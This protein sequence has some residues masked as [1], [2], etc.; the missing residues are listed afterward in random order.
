ML[1]FPRVQHNSCDHRGPDGQ[2]RPVRGPVARPNDAPSSET[3]AGR[4]P[5]GGVTHRLLGDP[6]GGGASPVGDPGREPVPVRVLLFLARR[7][8]PQPAMDFSAPRAARRRRLR[9]LCGKRDPRKTGIPLNP[10]ALLFEGKLT[11]KINEN[12]K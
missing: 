12:F 1:C 5:T 9:A 6:D 4:Q 7:A 11:K 2:R 3:P 10:L 8:I